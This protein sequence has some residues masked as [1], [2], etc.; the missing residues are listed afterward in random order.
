MSN[1]SG[2]PDDVS[3]SL[4]RRTIIVLIA[5][6]AVVAAAVGGVIGYSVNGVP[7]AIAAGLFLGLTGVFFGTFVYWLIGPITIKPLPVIL[8]ALAVM[9]TLTFL[10]VY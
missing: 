2:P 6:P 3:E 1:R 5:L 10:V 8:L 4:V 9:A 7:G